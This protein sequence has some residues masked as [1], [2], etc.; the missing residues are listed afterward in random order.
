MNI[1]EIIKNGIPKVGETYISSIPCK[2]LWSSPMT[3]K[4]HIRNVKKNGQQRIML[5]SI[6]ML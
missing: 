4:R 5:L 3:Q 2:D 6:L 1:A